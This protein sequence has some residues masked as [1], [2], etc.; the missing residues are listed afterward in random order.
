MNYEIL[1][2]TFGQ[3]LVIME[4]QEFVIVPFRRHLYI[5]ISDCIATADDKIEGEALQHWLNRVVAPAE[6]ASFIK[7]DWLLPHDKSL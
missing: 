7:G 2:A 5:I 6:L 4:S 1:Q 3:E